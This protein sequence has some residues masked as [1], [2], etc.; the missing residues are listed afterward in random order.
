MR[1]LSRSLPLPLLAAG[2]VAAGL[3]PLVAPA[4]DETATLEQPTAEAAALDAPASGTE[5][6]P[7]EETL[8]AEA[9]AAELKVRVEELAK[10]AASDDA[11]E[12]ASDMKWAKATGVIACIGQALA[13][14]PQGASLAGDKLAIRD[15]ALALYEAG[16]AAEARELI[17]PL[18]E[19]MAVPGAANV[20]SPDAAEP[21]GV[22][23]YSLIESYYLMQEINDR[24][25]ALVKAM[26]RPRG[27]MEEAA[28]AAVMALLC[29]PMYAQGEDYVDESDLPGY[30]EL[31][32]ANMR[33][34]GDITE[35]LLAKDR[36]AVKTATLAAQESCQACH[37]K[38][39][40]G[41]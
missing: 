6:P 16:D 8:N 1:P 32:V 25:A 29:Y 41:E 19:A 35:A 37:K 22:D 7:V 26:R 31:T 3:G 28:N 23:W 4:A 9:L 39:R 11:F 15:A 5:L 2:L 27:T 20:D 14:H 12:E 21:D 30:Y 10:H 13:M 34:A 33:Q 40:D 18:R 36:R 38:Y 17:D 24:N